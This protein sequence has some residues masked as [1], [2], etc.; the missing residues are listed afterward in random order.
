MLA[1]YD[2]V[3]QVQSNKVRRF[4]VEIG[5]DTKV[6]TKQKLGSI[7]LDYQRK[8]ESDYREPKKKSFKRP[9]GVR[10]R[11][12]EVVSEADQDLAALRREEADQQLVKARAFNRAF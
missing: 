2:D 8:V 3:E 9:A 1:K 5:R 11:I 12:E 4:K 7:S 10:P 6:E